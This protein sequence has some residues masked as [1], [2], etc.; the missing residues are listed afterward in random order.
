MRS[1]V[2]E[3]KDEHEVIIDRYESQRIGEGETCK[4]HRSRTVEKRPRGRG[5]SNA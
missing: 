2:D 4:F 1:Y 5:D 3:G